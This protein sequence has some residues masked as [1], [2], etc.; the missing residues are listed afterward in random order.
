MVDEYVSEDGELGLKRRNLS[1]LGAKGRAEPAQGGG[2]VELGDFVL[3][4]FGEKL[5]LQVWGKGGSGSAN[6]RI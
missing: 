5:P 6:S 3:D 4:L 2:G 1:K